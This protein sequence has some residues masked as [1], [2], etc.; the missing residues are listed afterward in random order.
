MK[1]LLPLFFLVIFASIALAADTTAPV[2]T[3]TSDYYEVQRGDASPDF[4]QGASAVDN[5]DGKV[6]ITIAGE[7]DKD[8]AGSYLLE[9]TATDSAG[10]IARSPF[11]VLVIDK[12]SKKYLVSGITSAGKNKGLFNNLPISTAATVAFHREKD[13]ANKEE[14]GGGLSYKKRHRRVLCPAIY[15]PAYP[16]LPCDVMTPESALNAARYEDYI[17]KINEGESD[18]DDRPPA[19]APGPAFLKA[20][21]WCESHGGGCSLGGLDRNGKF[22]NGVRTWG[23]GVTLYDN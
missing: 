18:K 15:E 5:I 23:W 2:I 14:E 13:A 10:N 19:R 11:I 1:G 4:T 21:A 7:W 9:Y 17:V 12:Y 16:Y 8:V 22:S 20:R 3:V 6:A